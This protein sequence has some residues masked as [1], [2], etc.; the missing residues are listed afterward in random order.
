VF[1]GVASYDAAGM[2]TGAMLYPAPNAAGLLAAILTHSL[3]NEGAKKAQR[4]RIQAD[5]DAV[6]LTYQPVL[7]GL[8]NER[9]I[10][11]ALSR[12][13][14]PGTRRLADADAV[15]GA[16]WSIETAPVFSMTRDQRAIVLDNAV[17]I[18]ALGGADTAAYAQT[19]R[20]AATPIP[21][22]PSDEEIPAV[23]LAAEGLR[24]ADESA[25]LL[26]E[27][28]DVAIADSTGSTRPLDAPHRTFRYLEGGTEEMERAQLVEE[29]CDRALIRTLRGWL[30]SIPVRA[31]GD[32]PACA[33]TAG[34][35]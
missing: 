16:D 5:A 17:R 18:Y 1:R 15:G 24:L 21:A 3:L 28:L 23:W 4:D 32:S 11:A 6:L 8:T 34:L 25:A 29:R 13:K 22:P 7:S 33:T 30:M 10:R 2:G 9:L 14:A 31:A 20:V 27:S 35:R 12:L 26:A 19:I